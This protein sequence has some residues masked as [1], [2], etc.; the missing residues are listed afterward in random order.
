MCLDAETERPDP[1]EIRREADRSVYGDHEE[2]ANDIC[3]QN[4]MSQAR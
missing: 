1:E 4:N 2:E 3:E